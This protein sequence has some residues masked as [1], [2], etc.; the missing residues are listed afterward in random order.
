MT[1]IDADGRI[2]TVVDVLC[3]VAVGA[4]TFRCLKNA[5]HCATRLRQGRNLQEDDVQ[6]FECVIDPSP[7]E[8]R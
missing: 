7:R 6:L 3:G 2:Y 8:W 5:R 1:K 4:Y